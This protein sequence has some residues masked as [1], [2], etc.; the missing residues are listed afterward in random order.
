MKP[1]VALT[2]SASRFKNLGAAIA[3]I[4]LSLVIVSAMPGCGRL[5]SGD[6]L[7][8]V[9]DSVD[10]VDVFDAKA[11]LSGAFPAETAEHFENIFNDEWGDF[12][13]LA[14]EV[15]LVVSTFVGSGF[16][17]T[18]LEGEFDFDKVRDALDRADFDAEEYRGYE[19]YEKDYGE[20]LVLIED[21]EQVI[22]GALLHEY[23]QHMNC[24]NSL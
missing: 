11:L 17:L 22:I 9:P 5:G 24:P 16:E 18:I 21:D 8:L 15:N 14:E 10:T 7:G 2:S 19:L 12:G 4:A 13:I 23:W 1:N 20:A 6:A 3:L